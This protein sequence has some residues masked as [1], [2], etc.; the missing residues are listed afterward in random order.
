MTRPIVWICAAIVSPVDDAVGK[1]NVV[2]YGV[3]EQ[4]VELAVLR[5]HDHAKE[6][7]VGVGE[8]R[9]WQCR[10]LLRRSLPPPAEVSGQR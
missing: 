2:G 10:R 9:R 4:V 8:G 5:G 1:T 3:P 7:R 6:L